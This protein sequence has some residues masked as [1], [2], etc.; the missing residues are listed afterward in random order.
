MDRF[1]NFS[2]N[3]I[4]QSLNLSVKINIKVYFLFYFILSFI[5]QF[6]IFVL[7]LYFPVFASRRRDNKELQDLG[8]IGSKKFQYWGVGGLKKI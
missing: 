4:T 8:E 3:W 5:S 7:D 2:Y 1:V 6:H